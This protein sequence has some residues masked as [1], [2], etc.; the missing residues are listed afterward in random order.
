MTSNSKVKHGCPTSS[1]S[2]NPC[3]ARHYG[4]KGR[5]RRSGTRLV[6]TSFVPH[7][8]AKK[9]ESSTA[10]GILA[11]C[12]P[13]AQRIEQHP[14]KLEVAGSIPARGTSRNVTAGAS[15]HGHLW[16][17]HCGSFLGILK[18]FSD[19]EKTRWIQRKPPTLKACSLKRNPQCITAQSKTVR[20]GPLGEFA[21][22][23]S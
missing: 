7:K 13:V 5:N 16:A 17:F 1:D 3:G 12:A 21:S 20:R 8:S 14:S 18:C 11:Y 22:Y 19:S 23:I 10:C 9:S 4:F 15:P 6:C 2:E